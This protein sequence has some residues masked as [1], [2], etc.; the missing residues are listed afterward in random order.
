MS[1][2]Y[3]NRRLLIIDMGTLLLSFILGVVL[4]HGNP[5]SMEPWKR[6]LYLGAFFVL[7][8]IR[9]AIYLFDRRRKDFIVSMDP[10]EN[11]IEVLRITGMTFIIFLM[12]L[13]VAHTAQLYSR[14]SFAYALITTI[15]LDYVLRMLWRRRLKKLHVR[16]VPLRRTMLVTNRAY[17]ARIVHRLRFQKEEQVIVNGITLLDE[18]CVGE[19]IEE[20]PVI[21]DR[22]TMLESRFMHNYQ[23]V[24]LY[25]PG[26]P[27]EEI[28][29]IVT[30]FGKVGM[31]VDVSLHT[32]DGD[33]QSKKLL[34]SV[35]DYQAASYSALTERC[36]ILGIDFVVG[37]VDAAVAN[38][39]RRLNDLRGEYITF[40]NVHTTV[41][42]QEDPEYMRTQNGAVMKF[43]DGTPIAWQERRRGF[44]QAERIAGPDFMEAM[45]RA[46]M[47]GSARHYFYGASEET[48]AHLEANLKL[49]YP[50]IAIAGLYSPPFRELTAE[51][52]AQD[53][54]RINDTKPDI[55]WIGLG[56]PKQEN[57]MAAHKGRLSGVMI[58]VGAGFDF[59]GGMIRRA[60]VWI[61]RL[62]M[63][64]FYRL[65]Q[66]PKRLFNRYFVTNFQ[67]LK[68]LLMKRV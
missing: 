48:I 59:H 21:A 29:R 53:I 17:A 22:A 44:P 32:F 3:Y 67:F 13:F 9:L 18:S 34:A 43:P 27:E 52:D 28:R 23:Y 64:W 36:R 2:R 31:N 10:V 38:V 7:I 40:S 60:P 30:E 61:Q 4:R 55:V 35:G 6:Q 24:F 37:N 5:N 46:T 58:G 1:R 45:F 68:Y 11:F 57:W 47:D 42:A 14:K 41:M 25:M 33:I 16:L 50:G 63:E 39:R 65:C 66:D 51:E 8:L 49:K 26:A 19:V 62:G 56:A 20:V 54:R 15:V 12:Y